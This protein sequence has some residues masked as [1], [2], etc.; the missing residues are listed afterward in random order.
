M[1]KE[2]LLN[3]LCSMKDKIDFMDSLYEDKKLE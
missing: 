1:N 2:E 3:Y